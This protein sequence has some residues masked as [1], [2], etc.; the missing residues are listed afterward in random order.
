MRGPR[1]LTECAVGKA[2]GGWAIERRE[3]MSGIKEANGV[4]LKCKTKGTVSSYS[5]CN[6]LRC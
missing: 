6:I 4:Q 1:Q 5:L 3:R 2:M